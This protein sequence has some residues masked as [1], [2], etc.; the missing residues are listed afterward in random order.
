MP[1]RTAKESIL[2]QGSVAKLVEKASRS[3]ELSHNSRPLG[4]GC[5]RM[6]PWK[7]IAVVGGKGKAR[8]RS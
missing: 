1:T 5:R 8:S 3:G 6:T 7:A 4:G 2:P